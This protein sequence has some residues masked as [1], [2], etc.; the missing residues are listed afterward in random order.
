[1]QAQILFTYDDQVFKTL[2]P[3]HIRCIRESEWKYALYF[4]PTGTFPDQYELYNLKSDPLEQF[5]LAH[6]ETP[7]KYQSERARLDAKLTETMTNTGT[8]PSE[9]MSS[10]SGRE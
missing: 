6:G 1:V 3:G 10:T 9:Y 5:N 7:R 8:L 4:D 2:G